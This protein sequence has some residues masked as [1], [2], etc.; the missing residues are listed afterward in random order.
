MINQKKG[1][2]EIQYADDD[3]SSVRRLAEMRVPSLLIGLVLGVFLS[4]IT[5]KFEGVIA[6]E[7]QVAF[8]IPFIVYMSDAVGTQ[9]QNIYAR[10]LR[11]GKASFKKY[12]MKESLLGLLLG[13]S[14]SSVA[15]AIIIAW[16]KSLQLALAVS[17]GMFGAIVSA[18]I[19]ALIVTEIL[20]LE[21]TDPAVGAGPIATVIQDAVSILIYG[22]IAT[23]IIL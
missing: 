3:I 7:V 8:F 18:P 12:L 21:H 20:Q 11:S 2:K 15:F 4:F 5:S 10:D 17:L 19:I 9:T 14:F 16:F 6:K 23:L 22:M 13:T 1:K